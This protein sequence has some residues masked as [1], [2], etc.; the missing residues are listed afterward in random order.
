MIL[1]EQLI[2][3]RQIMNLNEDS[4]AGQ[5]VKQYIDDFKEKY[6]DSTLIWLDTETTGL[7]QHENQITELAGIATDYKF[8]ILDT[9]HK[10]MKL[11]WSQVKDKEKAKKVIFPM[12]RYGERGIKYHDEKET[13]DEFFEWVD[14]YENPVLIA[15]NAAFDLEYLAV[16]G[17][18]KIDYPV[19]DTK[20]IIQLFFI[21][22]VQQL[23]DDENP[24]AQKILNSLPL[25]QKD[26][27]LPSSSMG[28]IAPTLD[29]DVT[30]WH[31]AIE[32]VK[33]MIEMFKKMMEYF[34]R[35]KDVDIRKYQGKRLKSYRM[36][37]K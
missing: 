11:D 12:T 26:M 37:D 9:F 1:Q 8:N 27:G 36:D 28:K 6:K 10:K 25:S 19:I 16:R 14:S 21:P 29:L 20:K 31:S 4:Y 17:R 2:R 13:I 5:S 24:E 32:D 22:A 18:R 30:G 33:I 34:E 35:N 15:Q 3:I 23:S 7:K